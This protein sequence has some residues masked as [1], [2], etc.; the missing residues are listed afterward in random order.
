MALGVSTKSKDHAC[1]ARLLVGR[2][3]G[4]RTRILLCSLSTPSIRAVQRS[5]LGALAWVHTIRLEIRSIYFRIQEIRAK[6]LVD[7][8][9]TGPA[10]RSCQSRGTPQLCRGVHACIRHMQS[11]RTLHPWLSYS[12]SN[13]VLEGWDLAFQLMPDSLDCHMVLGLRSDQSPASPAGSDSKPLPAT[14]QGSRHD[15]LARLPSQV[16]RDELD[17][18]DRSCTTRKTESPPHEDSQSSANSHSSGE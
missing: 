5:A 14:Q 15:W 13:L 10:C 16:L 6:H 1:D 12:D 18:R 3:R 9:G 17:S 4:S 2:P 8:Y 11:L 7:R